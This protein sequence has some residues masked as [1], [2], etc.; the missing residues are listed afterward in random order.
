MMRILVILLFAFA[1]GPVVGAPVNS[2]QAKYIQSAQDYMQR[3]QYQKALVQLSKARALSPTEVSIDEKMRECHVR[4][5]NWVSP[6][7]AATSSWIEVDKLRLADVQPRAFDSLFQV[8][9]TLENRENYEIAERIFSHLANKAPTKK[10]YGKAYQDLRLKVEL[11]SQNHI[12]VGEVFLKQGRFAKA[13]E[14]FKAAL[15]FKPDDPYLQSRIKLVESRQLELRETYKGRLAKVLAEGDRD[16]AAVIAERAFREFPSE[17]FFRRT[18]DSLTTLRLEMLAK[19]LEECRA[20]MD[21]SQFASA[22]SRLREALLSYPGEPQVVDLLQ[23]SRAKLE[24]SKKVALADSLSKEL[25][26]A[27]ETGNTS[28]AT[29]LLQN[30]KA[31]GAAG[32]DIAQKEKGL[33]SL[34]SRLQVQRDFE[35]TLEKARRLMKDGQLAEAR[36]ALEAAMGMNPKSPVAKQML[37]DVKREE[38]KQVETE[39]AKRKEIQ[40]ADA[41]VKAGQIQS[42]KKVDLSLTGAQQVDQE[43]KQVQRAIREAEY[44]RTPENDKKAQDLFFEGIGSYRLGDYQEALE[45][46]NK[47]LKLNPDHEQ[48]QKYVANVKQKLARMQ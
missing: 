45:K 44:A 9:K 30:L 24:S 3:S 8:A 27:I 33:D 17:K 37:E 1:W 4:L 23:Q 46:W 41:F 26:Q 18:L 2:E 38:A 43:V 47:V 13:L 12:E 28:L 25:T 15:F 14:E 32:D 31:T 39:D 34:K 48:A 29:S 22:E 5:G 16:Q 11:M 42:A 21:S 36:A 10:E 35:N 6:E 19:T 7:D 40:K 20:L